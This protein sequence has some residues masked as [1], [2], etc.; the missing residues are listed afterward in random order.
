MKPTESSTF[1]YSQL[2]ETKTSEGVLADHEKFSSAEESAFIPSVQFGTIQLR[3]MPIHSIT[4]RQTARHLI[5]CSLKNVGG[6]VVTPN[7]DILRRYTRSGSFRNLL[8]TS[9]LNVPDG[10][11]LIWAS[12]I[13][14]QPLSERVNGTDLMVDVCEASAEVG[15][16]VFFLGGNPGSAEKAAATLEKDFPGLKVAGCHCPEF[17][18]ETDIESVEKIAKIITAAD[19]DFVFVGLG[20]PKQDVLINMLRLKL[21]NVWWL[22]VGI[23]FSFIGGEITRAPEWAKKSGLEWFFRLIAEPRRLAKR[24]L[25]QGIPFF[26]MTL[27]VSGFERIWCRGSQ[28]D[29]QDPSGEIPKPKAA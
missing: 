4:R 1:D 29:L 18:F 2:N 26:A 19:P 10:M 22:G 5:D 13:K 7:L 8:A 23:S 21:P 15:K 20:S 9:T 17:G 25:L 3:G 11:P 27:M 12:R 16:S 6:W 14:G 24:Y 28:T